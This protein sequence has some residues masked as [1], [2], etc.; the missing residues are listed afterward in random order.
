M[1]CYQMRVIAEKRVIVEK[2]IKY[3]VTG[4]V[5]KKKI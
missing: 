1:T 3:S 4:R 5:Y 2:Y